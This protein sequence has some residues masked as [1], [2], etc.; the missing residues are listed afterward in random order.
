MAIAWVW[1]QSMS[2]I[3]GEPEIMIFLEGGCFGGRGPNNGAQIA[4]RH[5]LWCCF[6][7]FFCVFFLAHGGFSQFIT[8]DREGRTNIPERLIQVPRRSVLSEL[9]NRW[10][11]ALQTRLRA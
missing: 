9:L 10:F 7:G 1:N 4:R 2:R 6:V 3:L 11:D 5:W 8:T